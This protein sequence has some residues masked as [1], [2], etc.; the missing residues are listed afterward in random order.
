MIQQSHIWVYSHPFVSMDVEPMD[1]WIQKANCNGLEHP[2]ILVSVG[3]PGANLP[4]I[5]RDNYP[6]V[7]ESGS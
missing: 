3:G 2:W 5:A 7:L 4:Q 1:R 6:K